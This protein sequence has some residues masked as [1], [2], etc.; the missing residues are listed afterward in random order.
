MAMTQDIPIIAPAARPGNVNFQKVYNRAKDKD[1]AVV[2]LGVNGT[3]LCM[4]DRHALTVEEVRDCCEQG[5]IV[6]AFGGFYRPV[7]WKAI[8]GVATVVCLDNS[9]SS[10]ALA[11]KVFT[12]Y[13]AS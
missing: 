9:G 7:Y 13:Q 6:K 1:V 12:S 8:G 5:C 2:V 10:G 11:A 3:T 4:D